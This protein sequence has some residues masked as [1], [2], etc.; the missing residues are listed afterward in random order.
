MVVAWLTIGRSLT[1]Y[2]RTLTLSFGIGVGV[3]FAGLTTIFVPRPGVGAGVGV[4]VVLDD[5]DEPP[6]DRV[7]TSNA[8]IAATTRSTS[9]SVLR[10]IEF[11]DRSAPAIPYRIGLIESLKFHS[12][13]DTDALYGL[14]Y[15]RVNGLPAGFRHLAL[16]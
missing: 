7:K 3:G 6:P 11:E 8:T 14:P 16:G 9:S 4:G 1:A 10:V 2:R 13:A 12:A 5:A 15:C